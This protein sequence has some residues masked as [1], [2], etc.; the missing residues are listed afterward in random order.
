MKSIGER[1]NGLRGAIRKMT[2]H[3]DELESLVKDKECDGKLHC[4]AII[5]DE[6]GNRYRL[7]PIGASCPQDKE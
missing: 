5:R 6:T 4:G 1:I 2:A 7:F 3:L